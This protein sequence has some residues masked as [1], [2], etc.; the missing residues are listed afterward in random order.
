MKLKIALILALPALLFGC[1]KSSTYTPIPYV[2]V[3]F[4]LNIDDAL[5]VNLNNLGGTAYVPDQG[6]KGIILVNDL[7]GTLH[8]YDRACPY[9]YTDACALVTARGDQF[10]MACGKYVITT[11]NNRQVQTW[12]SCCGSS[13]N[14]DGTIKTGPTQ[15][16]LKRYT[17]T[18]A[19]S[20]LNVTN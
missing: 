2:Y 13:W 16:G 7:N 1:G 10:D 8:A 11:V 19:G 18:L 3:S 14:L 20:V 9:N 5:Y 12:Q 4:Q 6:Y 15:Y 17:A